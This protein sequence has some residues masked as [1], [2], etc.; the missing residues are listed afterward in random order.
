VS[1]PSTRDFQAPFDPTA[2]ASITGAQLLQFIQGLYP[3]INEGIALVTVDIA[4]VPQVPD[5]N[6]NTKWRRY[7]WI[8]QSATS[9]G[10]YVWNSIAASDATY[11]QWQSV[12]IAGIGAGSI[13]NNMI[14]DNTIESIKIV[15]L[16]YSKLTGAPTGLTPSGPAGGDLT[17]TYP[18]PSIGAG[19]VVTSNVALLNITNALIENASA[20]TGVGLAKLAPVSGSAKDMARVNAGATGMEAFTPPILFTGGVVVPTANALKVPRVNAGATDFEMV[21]LT[22]LG[23]VLQVVDTQSNAADNTA[24]T[25]TSATL[26]TTSNTK[27]IAALDTAVTPISSTSTLF[28]EVCIFAASGSNAIIGALF[29][30]A[31]TNAI[32]A[33]T[34]HAGASA[35]EVQQMIFSY[36]VV[37]GS[38]TARTFHAGYSGTSAGTTK[39]NSSDGATKLFGGTLGVNSWV[40]VTEYI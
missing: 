28:V 1:Q 33:A 13:V 40:R 35:T 3:N 14:A 17:G 23:R 25:C 12:N 26:P 22:S 10:L 24:L 27:N 16:D 6:T 15:S 30:D 36:K 31:G 2:Y 37:S 38:T 20:T 39:L 4:T 8:R 7:L 21:S 9:V 34:V 5:A 32:A 18:N 11:L 19:K 29:Q